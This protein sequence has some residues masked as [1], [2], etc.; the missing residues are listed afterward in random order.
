[1]RQRWEKLDVAIQIPDDEMVKSVPFYMEEESEDEDEEETNSPTG[2]DHTP[3]TPT[4]PE[5]N[6]CPVCNSG[7]NPEASKISAGHRTTDQQSSC[8]TDNTPSLTNTSSPDRNMQSVGES[9]DMI[10]SDTQCACICRPS[11]TVGCSGQTGLQCESPSSK[12]S[13]LC[14]HLDG[15]LAP[16]PL[17]EEEEMNPNC[18]C[19]FRRMSGSDV[20]DEN[21]M[22][23]FNI[24]DLPSKVRIIIIII[25]KQEARFACPLLHPI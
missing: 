25:Y 17:Q 1:M 2:K 19:K 14:E 12:S 5:T 22:A 6:S 7:Q 20:L 8:D 24:L 23:L 15:R 16:V 4:K 11:A 10:S 18:G 13:K 9:T 21:G 3:D